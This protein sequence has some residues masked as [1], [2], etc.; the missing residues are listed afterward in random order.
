MALIIT[1]G[2]IIKEQF[3]IC[4]NDFLNSGYIP[5]LMPES[6][7]IGFARVLKN[8]AKS[9]GQP[10]DTD[11]QLF[12]YLILQVRKN[13][14]MIVCMSPIGD[15][16]RKRTAKFPGIVNCCS[17]D[18]FHAWPKEACEKVAYNFLKEIEFETDEIR[19]GVGNFMS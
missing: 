14:K 1:D 10:N 8:K 19:R 9:E 11:D 3:L 15:L 4:I 12:K 17:V 2:Q 5:E 16:M 6:E 7:Y 18:F 13:L